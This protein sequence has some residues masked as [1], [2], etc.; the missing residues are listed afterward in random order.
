MDEGWTRWVFEQHA[1]RHATV[2][3]SGVRAGQLDGL[4]VLVV[5]DMSVRELREGMSARAVPAAYAGGLGEA[6]IAR[7]G[8]FVRNG[9]RLVLLDRSTQLARELGLD[10][11]FVTPAARRG[12][13]GGGADTAVTAAEARPYAPG[14][15]LRALVDARHPLAAGMADTAAVYFTNSTTLDVSRVAGATVVARYPAEPD[16]LLMS[17]YLSG[18]ASI[19]GRTALALAPLGRGDVVLF[20][21]RP[22]HR[23]QSVGTFKLLFN[24]LLGAGAP[25]SRAVP[26]R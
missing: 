24:A 22:Q 9:G 12:E 13:D 19:A 20:G 16:A 4:D 10:V 14:S 6:G 1:V 7:L 18:A 25:T 3:D 21:F 23:A 8:A 5:P 17:G 15:I 2:T 26:A 11:G